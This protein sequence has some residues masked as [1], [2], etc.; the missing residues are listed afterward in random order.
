MYRQYMCT[1][2]IYNII[3]IC[4]TFISNIIPG[5]EEEQEEGD[6]VSELAAL[7]VEQYRN[8]LY[9]YTHVTQ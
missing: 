2:Y 3:S 9:I 7:L 6:F 1:R 4:M 5:E 8:R